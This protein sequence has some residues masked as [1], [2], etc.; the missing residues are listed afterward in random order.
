MTR[1]TI[2]YYSN[3]N[4]SGDPARLILEISERQIACMVKG[5]EAQQLHAFELF[6]IEKQNNGWKEVFAALRE[7][8]Q[9][10]NRNYRET[11]C[12]YNCEEAL[13]IPAEKFN[14]GAAEDFLSLVYGEKPQHDVKHDTLV[15]NEMVNAYRIPKLMHDLVGANFVLYKPHHSYSS[16]LDDILARPELPAEFIKLQLYSH[17]FILAFVKGGKLQL[18]R[19]FPYQSAE[20]ILYYLVSI[21]QQFGVSATESH[22]EISGMLD[23]DMISQRQ[24]QKM[25]GHISFDT[26]SGDDA[27]ITAVSLYPAY[28]F[29][30]FYK[31]AV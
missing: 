27:F 28:Y 22:L 24:L 25:F 29:T 18:V 11:S 9:I 12:Y 8:S 15:Q 17:H 6:E 31:L 26:V 23:A 10:L 16:L 5:Q 2:G 20:D 13:I 4:N 14:T 7:E 1:K 30:P 21:I 3:T 19:S